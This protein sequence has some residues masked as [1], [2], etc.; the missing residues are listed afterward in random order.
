MATSAKN[1][2]KNNEFDLDL[3]SGNTARVRRPGLPKLLQAGILPD[4]LT[5]MAMEMVEKSQGKGKPQ[6]HKKKGET[7][8]IDPEMMKKFLSEEGALE[9]IMEAFDKVAAMVVVEPR[10]AF[11]KRDRHGSNGKVLRDVKGRIKTEEIPREERLSDEVPE[12]SP[13]YDE[14]PPL[15]TD[16]IDQDDKEFLFQFAVGGSS[17]LTSFRHSGDAVAD[18]HDGQDVELPSE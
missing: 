6:D 12:D 2:K 1:W 8:E 7:N 16:E 15:Y 4:D 14:N 11:H 13:Y 10:V 5:P 3:P 18:V 17:D 9:N